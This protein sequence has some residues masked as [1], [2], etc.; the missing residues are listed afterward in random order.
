[1]ALPSIVGKLRYPEKFYFLVH[2]AVAV[3]AA[4]GAGLVI[5]RRRDSIRVGLIASVT[6]LSM[7]VVLCLVCL[8]W[9]EGYLELIAI[10][11][12]RYLQ[13]SAFVPLALDTYW[14]AQRL[15]FILGV[16]VALLMLPRK[17]LRP[18]AV[19][20]LLLALVL[21]DLTSANRNLNQ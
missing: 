19:C 12:G 2:L 13:P 16:L 9:P 10:V 3:L 17:V 1:H 15:V 11:R 21:V 14:K 18:E 8:L 7:A 5:A 20:W 4:E 6:L